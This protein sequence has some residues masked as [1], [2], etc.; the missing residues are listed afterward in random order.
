MMSIS[1]SA[2]IGDCRSEAAE[3]PGFPSYAGEERTI[4]REWMLK[5]SALQRLGLHEILRAGREETDAT[6]WSMKRLSSLM[7][8]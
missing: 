7:A 4:L 6:A 5:S 1:G 8:S 3:S 2:G